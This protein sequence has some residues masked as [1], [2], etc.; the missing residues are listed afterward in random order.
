LITDRPKKDSGKLK[1]CH[2]VESDNSQPKSLAKAMDHWLALFDK[3]FALDEIPLSKRPFKAVIELLRKATIQ[4]RFGEEPPVDLSKPYDHVAQPWFRALYTGTKQWYLDHYGSKAIATNGNRPLRGVTL[5][6]GAPFLVKVPMHRRVVVE[7]GRTA[8]MYFEAGVGTG[9]D[10]IH[11]IIDPP[12]FEKMEKSQHDA[13]IARLAKVCEHLRGI[14]FRLLGAGTDKTSAGFQ[15]AVRSYLESAAERIRV[16]DLTDLGPAW[17]DLQMAAETALKL[18]HQ[19]VFKKYPHSH[20]LK[21]LFSALEPAI[22]FD[23]SRLDDWPSF[24]EMSDLRYAQGPTGGLATLF[25]AYQLILE[26]VL[27]ALSVLKP[28]VSSG[29]GLLLSAPSWLTDQTEII[30][31]KAS[32]SERT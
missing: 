26:A 24:K 3:R 15:R 16:G 18:A 9:E 25:E 12:N 10:P 5:V 29:S 30:E 11:W 31:T 32:L 13:D 14:N 27:A 22:T 17:F 23:L 8:W 6:R 7:E 19:T 1:G 21:P 4:I 20:E 28:P 2:M